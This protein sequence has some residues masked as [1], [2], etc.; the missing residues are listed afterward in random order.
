MPALSGIDI[1]DLKQLSDIAAEEY[2]MRK[3]AI[4]RRQAYYKG[5]QKRWMI[6]PITRQPTAENVIVNVSQKVVDQTVSFLFGD[7]PNIKTGEE[8]VDPSTNEGIKSPADVTVEFI[9]DENKDDIFY[10]N[11]GVLGSV[12]GHVFIKIIPDA[13]MGAR[14]VL[15]DPSLCTA[16]WSPDDRT[17]AIAYKIEWMQGTTAYRQDVIQDGAVWIVRDLRKLH[18][19][20]WERIREDVWPFEFAPI[21]DGQNLPDPMGYYGVS[22]LDALDLNDSINFTASNIGRILKFH[23]HPKTVATGVSVDQI[24]ATS[25]DGLWAIDSETAK[26]SNLEMQSDLASSMSYLHFLISSFYSQNRAVDIDS[27]RDKIGQLTNFGLRLLFNDALSKNSI[28][29]NMYKYLIKELIYRSLR[30]MN[31]QVEARNIDIEFSDPLPTNGQELAQTVKTE[32]ESGIISKQTGSEETGHDWA[33][34]QARMEQEKQSTNAGIGNALADAMRQ[35]DASNPMD[36][37]NTA[38]VNNAPAAT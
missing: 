20:E 29:Q 16:Y 37:E 15:Q 5:D 35:M 17:R 36:A 8:V 23:A 3:T 26:V 38:V 34:E 2:L 24:K 6:D 9:E 1:N 32:I 33:D 27:I 25:I 21:V 22:D 19:G 28:K 7:S 31:V 13:R 30:I 12:A 4:E 10:S 18:Q 11:V 14:W